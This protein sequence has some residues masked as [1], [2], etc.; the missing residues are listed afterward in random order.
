VGTVLKGELYGE[1]EKGKSIEPQD[2]G[3]LLNSS[4]SKAL[5]DKA[6]RGIRLKMALF[7]ILKDK[8][9]IPAGPVAR[10][11]RIRELIARLPVKDV[12]NTPPMETDP[13]KARALY[14]GIIAGRDPL[15]GEGIV[16]EPV[17]G[18]TPIKVKPRGES[19]VYVTSVFP[20]DTA[21][22]GDVRAGGFGYSNEP[23]G[24]EVGKVGTGISHATLKDMLA[25]PDQYIG[26]TARIRSRRQHASG[27]YDSPAFTAMHE[28]I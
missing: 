9:A 26:R 1:G 16:A 27:A 23:G 10:Q 6:D 15:T 17:E 19:D 5:K 25:S 3:G 12:F 11:A 20:A 21:R 28:D 2:L 22:T 4:L 13:A 14:E 24:P 18:G 7:G 8:K